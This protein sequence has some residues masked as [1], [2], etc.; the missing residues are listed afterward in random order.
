MLKH[1]PQLPVHNQRIDYVPQSTEWK[2]VLYLVADGGPVVF[3]P[4]TV[5]VT[6][7]AKR[8]APLLVTEKLIPSELL[9][10]RVPLQPPWDAGDRAKL[11]VI[12]D[13]FPATTS[14]AVV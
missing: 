9:D 2:F 1:C 5:T 8:P 10:V 3:F 7:K 6:K 13:P 12:T 4:D 14:V 11:I